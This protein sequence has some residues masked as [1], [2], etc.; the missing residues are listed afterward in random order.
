MISDYSSNRILQ[1]MFGKASG[2]VLAQN[3]YLAL[4]ST[5]PNKDGTNVTEP[6]GNGYARKLIGSY[7]Q[8]A[9]QYMGTPANGAITNDKE[10]HFDVATGPWGTLSWAA[11]YDQATNGNML[12]AGQI[13][14]IVSGEWQ[15]KTISPIADSV[16]V[17]KVNSLNFSITDN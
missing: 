1:C 10:I 2:L 15:P 4:S 7:G 12:A 11:V 6:S 17:L 3:C 14:E 16:V 8:A 9:S 13:G 5:K